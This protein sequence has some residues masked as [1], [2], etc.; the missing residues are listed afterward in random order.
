MF[1]DPEAE[2]QNGIIKAELPPGT[3]QCYLA[4]YDEDDLNSYCCGTGDVIVL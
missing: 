1:S 4:A 2:Y 3:F